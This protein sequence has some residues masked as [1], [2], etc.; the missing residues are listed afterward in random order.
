MVIEGGP[1]TGHEA[2]VAAG[3]GSPIIPLGR[4]GGRAGELH[5]RMNRPPAFPG[6]DWDLLAEAGA[7]HDRVV[8]AVCRLVRVSLGR[9]EPE[10]A[11]PDGGS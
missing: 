2:A 7:P 3:R 4:T 11:V 5:L 10:R 1:G 8:A 9:A 6:A